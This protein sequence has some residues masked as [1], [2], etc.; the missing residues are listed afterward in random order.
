MDHAAVEPTNFS[1]PK[2]LACLM[3]MHTQLHTPG[4]LPW[5]WWQP[6]HN[7]EHTQGANKHTSLKTSPGHGSGYVQIHIID[8]CIS[9]L[10]IKPTS[11]WATQRR[12][13]TAVG[14]PWVA[15]QSHLNGANMNQPPKGLIWMSARAL[16]GKRN[17]M[18]IFFFFF[19]PTAAPTA[20]Q[21]WVS[22]S[23]VATEQLSSLS[24]PSFPQ[25]CLF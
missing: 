23:H 22:V 7:P 9:D 1:D 8:K 19:L 6:E 4:Y 13:Q 15:N 10:F 18:C 24:L 16:H 11:R 3:N 17:I 14:K 5:R 21:T 20:G 2:T 12:S 25:E